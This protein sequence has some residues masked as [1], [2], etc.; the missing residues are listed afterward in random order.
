MVYNPQLWQFR[1]RGK[2]RYFEMNWNELT[3][4]HQHQSIVE[5]R[6]IIGP[7][8]YHPTAPS[9]C[10]K[11]RPWSGT[12]RGW[13]SPLK[14]RDVT[15]LYRKKIPWPFPKWFPIVFYMSTRSSPLHVSDQSDVQFRSGVV[16]EY[17]VEFLNPL[18]I[19]PL[20]SSLLGHKP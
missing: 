14:L 20:S 12:W 1:S 13:K 2:V 6:W 11:R 4:G 16:S 19:R 10:K 7:N 17:D 8:S 15:V 3:W 9:N 5:V 18:S